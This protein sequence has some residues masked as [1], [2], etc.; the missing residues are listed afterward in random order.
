MASS[1]I[2]ATGVRRTTLVAALSAIMV[3]ALVSPAVAQG[4]PDGSSAFGGSKVVSQQRLMGWLFGSSTNPLL[5]AGFCGEEIGGVFYLTAAAAPVVEFDC[6][7]PAGM[8]IVGT[9]GGT[10]GWMPT[11]ATTNAGLLAGL[12]R[13]MK[14]LA[15]PSAR[16][17]GR[18]LDVDS[19][20]TETGPYIIPVEPGSFIKTVDPAFPT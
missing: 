14:N 19:R 12:E 11:D 15:N 2:S 8:P 7:I 17:D 18:P 5:Q 9:P 10:L 6:E 1:P 3:A 16:L 4:V 20:L 13:S